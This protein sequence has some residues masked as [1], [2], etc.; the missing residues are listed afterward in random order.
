MITFDE[1]LPEFATTLLSQGIDISESAGVFVRD[2]RGRLVFVARSELAPALLERVQSQ[3]K[4]DLKPYISPIGPIADKTVPGTN[5]A[6]KDS[7]GTRVKVNLAEREM[8]ITVMLL[9]RRAVGADWLHVPEDLSAATPRLVFSS[10]KGGVGRSTALSVLAAELAEQGRSLLVLD[11]DLEAPGL[12]SML[13]EDSATPRFGSIDFFVEDSLRE[14]DDTFLQD[15]IGASWLGAGRGRIDVVPAFGAMSL[16]YPREVLGKLARAYV[17][18]EDKNGEPR[19]FLKRTQTL[20]TRLSSLRRY[21]AVLVDTRAGLHETTAAAILGLG[22]D[23]LLF[24]VH[25]PQT[26]LGYRILLSH[27]A[28]LPVHDTQHDWRYRLRMVHAKAENNE[29]IT[30]YRTQ[31]YDLFDSVFYSK[32]DDPHSDIL[33]QGFRFSVDDQ[34]APH[35]PIPIFEDARYRLFDPVQDRTQLT[36]GLYDTSFSSFVQFCVE[37]LQLEEDVGP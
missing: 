8:S 26:L 11:L 12:G 7:S 28:Q 30:A 34:E 13:I 2:M 37:R 19:T 10:L 32:N 17:D 29:I 23:V 33:E 16:T 18:D 27:L 6:L 25:Q 3:I 24:G 20:V 35:Y 31:L 15:C 4:A 36:K 9:D 22:A 1:S 5:R 21:D 14:L